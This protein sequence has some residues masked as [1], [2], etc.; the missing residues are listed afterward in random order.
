MFMKEKAPETEQF[1]F[2]TDP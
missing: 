2:T 1:H